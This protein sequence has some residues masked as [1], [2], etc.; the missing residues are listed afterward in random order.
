MFV[1]TKQSDEY[2]TVDV[3]SNRSIGEIY[4]EVGGNFVFSFLD[5]PKGYFCEYFFT[6]VAENLKRLN[7]QPA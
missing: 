3:S 1:L 6:F 7:S 5:D 4:K 2:Y